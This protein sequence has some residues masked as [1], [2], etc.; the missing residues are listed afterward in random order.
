MS[1][2]GRVALVTGAGR[3]IGKAIAQALAAKGAAVAVHYHA[4]REGAERLAEEIRARGGKALAIQADVSKRGDVERM[5]G[6]CAGAL[7]PADILV[8]NARQ[9]AKGKPFMDLDW[10][11]YEIQIDVML[12]GAF[13]CCKAVLPSMIQRRWGRVVN[14]L[15]TAL[16]DHRPR[17]SAYGTVKSALLYFS[18]NLATEIGP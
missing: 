1:L 6:Q 5:A 16:I 15:S 10:G 17:T 18:Q 8:N 13:N 2:A 9:L 14:V 3:G 4:S 7:G 12:R 11:D